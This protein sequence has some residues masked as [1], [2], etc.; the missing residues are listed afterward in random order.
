MHI[1]KVLKINDIT[2]F[3]VPIL[4]EYQIKLALLVEQMQQ[5]EEKCWHRVTM[6]EHFFSQKLVCLVIG[7]EESN[8]LNLCVISTTLHWNTNFHN[9]FILFYA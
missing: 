1:I 9:S 4:L 3:F 6:T 7:T 8:M 2:E 5:D